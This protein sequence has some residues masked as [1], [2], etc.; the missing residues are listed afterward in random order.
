[1]LSRFLKRFNKKESLDDLPDDYV[2]SE[3][4]PFMSAHQLA[5]FKRSLEKWRDAIL[6]DTAETIEHLQTDE[7]HL[8]DATDRASYETERALELRTRDRQ[9]KLIPKINEALRRIEIGSYGYCEKTGEP[10]SL[11]RLIARPIATLGIE[12][13]EMHE[14]QEKIYY[15]K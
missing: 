13:Q 6:N 8:P 15:H 9:R 10:I 14:R 1:M 7:K 12:A 3:D 5:Y 4:E 11:K 2:P